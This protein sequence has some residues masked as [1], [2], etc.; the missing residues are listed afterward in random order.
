MRKSGNADDA[1]GRGPPFSSC[2]RQDSLSGRTA[3]LRIKSFVRD[4]GTDFVSIAGSGSAAQA[5]EREIKGVFA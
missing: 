5:R 1:A 3:I 4:C 2:L